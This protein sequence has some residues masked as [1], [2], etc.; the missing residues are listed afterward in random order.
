LAVEYPMYSPY[1]FSA[2]NPI[3]FID[4]DGERINWFRLRAALIAR[5]TLISTPTGEGVWQ[6]MR[7]SGSR[8]NLHIVPEVLTLRTGTVNGVI[9]NNI[10]AGITVARQPGLG[11]RNK[12]NRD[13]FAR[14]RR[15]NL[16]TDKTG[17]YYYGSVDVFVSS[18]TF[19]LVQDIQQQQGIPNFYGLSQAQRQAAVRMQL[20]TGNYNVVEPSLTEDIP[21]IGRTPNT[22]SAVNPTANVSLANGVMGFNPSQAPTPNVG[23]TEPEFLNRVFTHEGTHSFNDAQENGSP[24]QKRRGVET[25]PSA[26]ESD[27]IDEQR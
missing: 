14:D 23:E 13:E 16:K 19:E 20:A 5:K 18:G 8:I 2:D 24:V 15:G 25:L 9:Q 21:L 7:K 12:P 3:S 17:R 11:G 6:M 26:N 4:P 10:V 22:L 1:T 27:T